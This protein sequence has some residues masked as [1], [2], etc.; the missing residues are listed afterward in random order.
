MWIEQGDSLPDMPH[1]M[2]FEAVCKALQLWNFW[3][4]AEYP[5]H[6]YLVDIYVHPHWV[7]EVDGREHQRAGLTQERDMKKT[8]YLHSLG[9]T[10][11]RAK[12][13][14][15]MQNL[16]R[17]VEK[18]V[19]LIAPKAPI[20]NPTIFRKKNFRSEKGRLFPI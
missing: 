3:I 13:E 1:R 16:D 10:V 4:R 11:V 7:I 18:I 15:V 9:I 8:Q 17:E 14:D 6:P 19:S 2:M 20:P 5:F 12:N